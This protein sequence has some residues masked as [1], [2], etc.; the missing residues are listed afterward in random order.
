MMV[1]MTCKWIFENMPVIT[2]PQN[3]CESRA[4]SDPPRHHDR[5][6]PAPHISPRCPRRKNSR[7]CPTRR[8]GGVKRR[9]P[10]DRVLPP[11]ERGG[12]ARTEGFTAS[13]E[14]F[15]TRG[16]PLTNFKTTFPH[17]IQHKNTI[18]H[19]ILYKYHSGRKY[20]VR[21][22]FIL[23]PEPSSCF[24]REGYDSRK[25]NTKKVRRFFAGKQVI[26]L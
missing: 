16:H 4:P 26:F 17:S 20:K 7:Q 2:Y 19:T 8:A 15:P 22:V 11:R 5:A 21:Y 24:R 23:M 13:S 9:P 12:S 1:T 6:T 10:G 18:I 3:S 14:A 25:T